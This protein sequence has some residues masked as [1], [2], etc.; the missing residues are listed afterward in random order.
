MRILL[1]ED[2]FSLADIIKVMLEKKNYIV[3][4]YYDGQDALDN[5]DNGYDCFVLDINVPRLDG[6]ILLRKIKKVYRKTP[7]VMISSNIEL[8]IIKDAYLAGCSDFLKKPFYMY[9]LEHK[10]NAL[11]MKNEIFHLLEGYTYN[12]SEEFLYNEKEERVKLSRKEQRFMTLL[13]KN[14][15]QTSS[16]EEIEQYVWE[17]EG[18]SLM[19]IRSLVK[20]LKNKL[21]NGSIV[22]Q[23]FAYR[24]ILEDEG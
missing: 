10:I 15:C 8:D 18:T 20:R 22:A 1:L 13:L 6:I 24:L 14:I 5:F 17:D 23:N 12:L 21:P 7:V 2:N 19:G 3:D 16:H 4:L 11:C 9:E